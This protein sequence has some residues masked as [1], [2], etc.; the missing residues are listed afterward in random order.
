MS[1]VDGK[2]VIRGRRLVTTIATTTNNI[3]TTTDITNVDMASSTE[4]NLANVIFSTDTASTTEDISTTTDTISTTTPD[5]LVTEEYEEVITISFDTEGNA[6]FAGEVVADKVSTGGLAVTG[7][8]SF[9]GGLEVNSIGNASTT[10]AMLS[11]VDFFGRPY[12]TSDT[13]G[14][15]VIKGG[16]KT[17]DVVFDREYVATP[18]VNASMVFGTSTE[19]ADIEAIFEKGV[20]FVVTNRTEKGFTIRINT[21]LEEDVE[22]SWTAIAVKD[23]KVFTSRSADITPIVE[24]VDTATTTP[25]V[26]GDNGTTTPIV[27]DNSTT[28]QPVI[29][30]STTT[31]EVLGG[32]SSTTPITNSEQNTVNQ[33]SSVGGD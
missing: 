11:D 25:V 12:F 29:D 16:A 24:N 7:V 13:G 9:A 17:V 20:R 30:N 18:I 31:P 5:V 21:N 2:L 4:N 26:T 14:T 33:N 28:T 23:A 3:A 8:A 1:L 19:D 22:F 27:I 32:N 10:I 15:A 6:Y